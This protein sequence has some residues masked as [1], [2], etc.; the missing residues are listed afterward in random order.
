MMALRY[1]SV[2]PVIPAVA[3]RHT[4]ESRYPEI[5][6]LRDVG[7]IQQ[8]PKVP[9]PDALLTESETCRNP[10]TPAEAGVTGRGPS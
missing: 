5:H 4:D 7:P 3:P 1:P 8:S 9:H 2:A 10:W 6:V